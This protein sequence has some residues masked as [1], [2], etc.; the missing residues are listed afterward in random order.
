MSSKTDIA[1]VDVVRLLQRCRFDLSS[2]K[3]LQQDIAQ[4]FDADGVSYVR[5]HRLSADDIPDFMVGDGILVECKMRNKS[6]RMAI[7]NQL[8]RY[9]G[10]DEVKVIILASNVS[11]GLPPDINGK[12]LYAASLSQGWL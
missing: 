2:E 5:E 11:M 10:H 8:V 1:P 4:A 12:P 3:H 6:K 7:F 9:A